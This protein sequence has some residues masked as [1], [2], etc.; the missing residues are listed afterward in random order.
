MRRCRNLVSGEVCDYFVVG[1][2]EVPFWY[3]TD[4]VLVKTCNYIVRDGR[5]CIS[6]YE[7]IDL[8]E[9]SFERILE[10]DVVSPP[11][12]D[13]DE[14]SD[15]GHPIRRREYYG[16]NFF[17]CWE[18]FKIIGQ[19]AVVE[20][21]PPT[22]DILE[23]G[24]EHVEAFNN[25]MDEL[26][27]LGICKNKRTGTLHTFKL[28]DKPVDGITVIS[29]D[30]EFDYFTMD[31]NQMF[32]VVKFPGVESP[33]S[34]VDASFIGDTLDHPI[35]RKCISKETRNVYDCFIVGSDAEPEWFN[36]ID[37][38]RIQEIELYAEGPVYAINTERI[39][40]YEEVPFFH[41]YDLI[42]DANAE[43]GSMNKDEKDAVLTHGVYACPV[44]GYGEK[45]AAAR[46][47]RCRNDHSVVH[48]YFVYGIDANPRWFNG[49][50]FSKGTYVVKR[51][52]NGSV[53]IMM[54]QHDFIR[55]LEVVDKLVLTDK[56]GKKTENYIGKVSEE[57]MESVSVNYLCTDDGYTVKID[58]AKYATDRIIDSITNDATE[59]PEKMVVNDGDSVAA[60]T[61]VHTDHWGEEEEDLSQYIE[62]TFNAN[63][64]KDENGEE[65]IYF[66][67]GDDIPEWF[68]LSGSH[69]KFYQD[70]II[71]YGWLDFRSLTER[72]FNY[73]F[74]EMPGGEV[75][76]RIPLYEEENLNIPKDI[77]DAKHWFEKAMNAE[78]FKYLVLKNIDEDGIVDMLKLYKSETNGRN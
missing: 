22:E 52:D 37:R 42:A 73:K 77:K 6:L 50:A 31:F 51:G 24:R 54:D 63:L 57:E 64:C 33:A 45:S 26:N 41:S 14:D 71:Y 44:G 13:T 29:D 69:L 11:P 21:P 16:E 39:L 61:K 59:R 12:V 49:T 7:N 75:T 78:V 19:E 35:G 5:G 43:Y 40:L 53:F 60:G 36:R 4:G 68:K 15:C 10:N 62:L 56:D 76:I 46:F 2:D 9:G 17:K 18:C 67:K 47:C 65:Y 38:T 70:Y 55:N 34:N 1:Y 58:A 25:R 32:D 28:Y 66:K 48:E 23:K 20:S 30:G 27:G 8:F 74:K 72:K 3:C